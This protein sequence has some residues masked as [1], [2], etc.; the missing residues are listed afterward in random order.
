MWYS[1]SDGGGKE[2]SYG[3]E[4]VN[5]KSFDEGASLKM[6]TPLINKSLLKLT[7]KITSNLFSENF[8]AIKSLNNS[9]GNE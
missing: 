9:G 8:L 3:F 6:I 7:I 2:R 5:G 4:T 1:L